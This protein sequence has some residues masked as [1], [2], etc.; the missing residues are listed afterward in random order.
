MFRGKSSSKRYLWAS[1]GALTLATVTACD[2][3]TGKEETSDAPSVVGSSSEAVPVLGADGGGEGGEMGVDPAIAEKDPTIF[4]EALDVIRAHFLAGLSSLSLGNREE[5]SAMFAHPASEVYVDLEPVIL[6]FGGVSFLDEMMAAS[7]IALSDASMEEV[8]AAAEEVFRAIDETAKLAPSDSRPDAKIQAEVLVRMID[9]AALQ[10]QFAF[11]GQAF[12]DSWLDGHGFYQTAKIR[13]EAALPLV[14][15]LDEDIAKEIAEA[16][17]VLG[18]VYTSAVQ[19][20][21]PPVDPG[22]ILSAA[23]RAALAVSG[24]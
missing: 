12:E 18:T 20:S 23:S 15:T 21:S 16:I 19:P 6:K 3:E 13:G 14:Q 17:V 4:L 5:A 11:S 22:V 24:L 1:V 2:R 7:E 8:A 10:Y 9:R